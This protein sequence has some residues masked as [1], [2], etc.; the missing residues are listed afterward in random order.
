MSKRR[1]VTDDE[2]GPAS[3]ESPPAVNSNGVQVSSSHLMPR[4]LSGSVG[5]IITALA[6]TPLEVVK[7]RQQSAG[8]KPMS[9][10][11]FSG[12]EPC[13]G[14]GTLVLN[15]GLMECSIPVETTRS[16][17]APP[18]TSG[19][20]RTLFSIFKH[21]GWSGIYAGLRPTL[22]MSIPSTVLYFTAYD[23]ISTRLRNN[24]TLNNHNIE[25]STQHVHEIDDDAR[26]QAYIPLVAGST[27]RLLA[28]LSTAPLELVRTRQ[29]SAIGNGERV[30]P[31][32][33][34]EFRLL[35]RT[36]GFS[37][38]FTGLAPTLWRDV[39]FS[40]IY[41]L[42]LEKFRNDLSDSKTLG[43]WGGGYYK[44]QG[45][46]IP[47]SV[48]VMHSFV[49]GAGAGAIAA[50]GTTPFDVV[51]TRRQMSSQTE[52]LSTTGS[53][54]CDHFGLKEYSGSHNNCQQRSMSVAA[55]AERSRFNNVGTFGHM[56]E[57]FKDE[58]LSG[59]WRGNTTRMVKVA[60]ACAVM[61]S[62]YEF[63]KKVF[64]EIV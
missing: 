4:I 42:F 19:T 61:I 16:T 48:E 11:N 55:A 30:V 64:G 40:A 29:A 54:P 53:G 39:P 18:H 46:T 20:F 45:M 12:I 62:C 43:T 36:N 37:S 27:S 13:R 26:R 49:S 6:V 57:I 9:Y 1:R 34:E 15:N 22:L 56:R 31:G 59:L 17:I 7:I 50:F 5:S 3:L 51:K 38:L 21:E 35:L 10:S 28:S 60:P 24:H 32:M 47:P 52:V 33:M 41:W 58:G 8:V 63:G 25:Q 23:E 14:C 44:D 2:P